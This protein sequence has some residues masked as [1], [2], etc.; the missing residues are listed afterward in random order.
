MPNGLTPGCLAFLACCSLVLSASEAGAEVSVLTN[1]LNTPVAVSAQSRGRTVLSRRLAPSESVPVFFAEDLIVRFRSGDRMA[2]MALRPYTVYGFA[3]RVPDGATVLQQVRLGEDGPKTPPPSL[4]DDP[5]ADSKP[6]VVTVK[7][8]VDEDEPRHRHLWEQRL[9]QRVKA[10][11]AVIEKH[12]GVALEVVAVQTWESNDKHKQFSRSLMEF[13]REVRPAPAQVAIGFSSQYQIARGRVHLGGTRGPL[14]P[15]ILLKERSPNVRETERAELL[16]HELGHYLGAAHSPEPESVMR[17]VI[18]GGLQRARGA[19]I[20]FDPVS[21]LLMG[22]VA[23]EMRG[24]ARGLSGLTAVTRQR[25]R[26]VYTAV[27]KTLPGDTAAQVL[28]RLMGHNSPRGSTFSKAKRVLRS[29]SFAAAEREKAASDSSGPP[30]K[31]GDALTNHYVR[32]AAA[33]ALGVGEG[34][35][36]RRALLIGMGVFVDDTQALRQNPLTKT[37]CDAVE[38]EAERLRRL[39]SAGVPTV[40][41]RHDLAKHFFISALLTSVT[42]A[43]RAEQ[44]G[45]AKEV[46][47]ANGGSG[48]SFADMAANYAGVRFASAVIDGSADL[49]DIRGGFRVS[50]FLPPVDGFPEGLT[51]AE[52]RERYPG[53]ELKRELEGV[54]ELIDGL[55]V[56]RGR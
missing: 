22:M 52:L 5:P 12:A 23:E 28:V 29:L 27:G 56:Y 33:A 17:P 43:E 55:P 14:H 37:I 54:A 18:T 13:E 38:T 42:S 30:P 50:D 20:R 9:R 8:L 19:Q 34:E 16:V 21:T 1:W 6:F 47:D 48:F 46:M 10:A 51:A 36:A 45:L 4:P 32:H 40:H 39:E 24:G 26:G 53:D 44:I 35:E 41:D 11:S 3:L 49:G 31:A 7:L 15:W 2:T 25:M